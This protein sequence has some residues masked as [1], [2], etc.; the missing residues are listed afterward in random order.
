MYNENMT[1]GLDPGYDIGQLSTYPD[2]EIYTALVSKDN[3]VNFAQQALPVGDAAK[4]VVPVG[5][6][7]EKGGLVTF[8][9]SVRPIGNG[10]FYLEDK[11]TG[12]ITDLSKDTY[13]VNLPAS[14]AGTGRSMKPCAAARRT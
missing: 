2:V 9:A 1:T 10:T 11:V 6:D 4:S 3:S 14:T 8:S 13:T 12:T 7:A 5:V